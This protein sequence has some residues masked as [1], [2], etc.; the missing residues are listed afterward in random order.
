MLRDTYGATHSTNSAAAVSAFEDAVGRV[1]SHRPIGTALQTALSHDDALAAAHAL[2]GFANVILA[3]SETV[4]NAPVYLA[5]AQSGLERCGGGSPS[6]RALVEALELC[7]AGRLRCAAARLDKHLESQPLDFL[8]LKL[9][10]SLRFMSGQG[11]EMLS[12]TRRTVPAWTPNH[13]GYGFV[14]GC[15]AFGLEEAGYFSAAEVIGRQAYSHEQSDAW[16]LHAVSHVMEMSGRTSE[17]VDWLEAA[18][19][20]WSQCNN[21]SFHMSWHL[22]LFLLEQG[23]VEAVLDVYDREIRPASTDDFRD[24]ANATSMLWRLELEGVAVGARW[25]ELHEIASKRRQD[26]TYVF[27]SLHYLLALVASGDRTGSAELF[28]S[29]KVRAGSATDD[30][31]GVAASVGLPLAEIIMTMADGIVCSSDL[32][33]VAVNLPKIG[34]SH[35]QRDVFLRT[36]LVAARDQSNPAALLEILR[37]RSSLRSPDRFLHFVDARVHSRI[38]PTPPAMPARWA[39]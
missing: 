15:H 1:A 5:A 13:A 22:A 6:E 29:L 19:P 8:A 38:G 14:L 3:R 20:N 32:V 28:A 11:A 18:R 21:F 2:V 34:G 17:G 25:H 7:V 30:Q 35:A 33:H 9:S 10:H 36:L 4:A 27:G 39:S 31:A 16:G 26:M 12:L 37:I 24:M 23:S